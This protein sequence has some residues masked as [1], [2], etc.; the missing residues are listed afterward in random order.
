MTRITLATIAAASLLAS[1]SGAAGQSSL[2]AANWVSRGNQALV[3]KKYDEALEFF[4][5]A[6]VDLPD[7]AE[8]AYD[9]GI[10]HYRKGDFDKAREAFGNA[11]RTRDPKLEAKAKFNLGNC[12]YSTALQKLTDLPGA[13]DELRKSINYW[14]DSLELNPGDDA[15]RQNIETAQLLIK[16]LLDKEKKRQ[17]EEQKKQQEQQQQDQKDQ[18]DQED[19]KQDQQQQQDQQKKDEQK[20]SKDQEQDQQQQQQD[21]QK[22]NKDKKD[23]DKQKKDQPQKSGQKKQDQMSREDAERQLQAIRDKERA[24]RDDRRKQ[25]ALFGGRPPVD[26]DW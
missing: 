24:R 25:E 8:I 7:A 21:Q 10:A 23:K 20:N 1:A 2:A 12:A 22:Q 26:K 18:K 16:D 9:C 13:I 4:R 14:R 3:E 19:Q 11:L 17:E 15:A 6:E 5:K